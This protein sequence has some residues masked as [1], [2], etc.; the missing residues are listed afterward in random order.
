MDLCVGAASR[1]VVE[2]AAKLQVRQI[3]ASRAQVNATGGYI[4]MTPAELVSEVAR[5][6]EGRTDVVRDHGGPGQGGFEDDGIEAFD[7]DVKSGFDA[8]HVDVCKLVPTEQ[9][10]A[11]IKLVRRF[12][13]VIEVEVGGEH[14]D[15]YW[16]LH[17]LERV[18]AEG[19]T[20]TYV[21]INPGTKVWADTQFGR[22]MSTKAVEQF[23]KRAKKISPGTATKVHNCDWW[24]DRRSLAEAGVD[25]YNVAPELGAVEVEALLTVLDGSSAR[26][27]LSAGYASGRWRRWF[28]EDRKEGTSFQ[29]A[30]CGLRYMQTDHMVAQAW[31]NLSTGQEDYVRGC[32]RDAI[33]RG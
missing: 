1:R 20:P 14:T 2:E 10:E 12:H 8:L 7:L 18:R 5:L 28:R 22:P 4:G 30:K 27:L 29:R 26:A 23:V 15:T 21:V 32:I 19:V 31:E 3:V 25:C 33:F 24:G 11:L 9:T 16:N 6:S 13:D 17:L